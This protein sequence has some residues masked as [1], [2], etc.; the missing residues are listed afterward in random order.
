LKRIRAVYLDHL[1]T[2][3]E[4]YEQ[5]SR[6]LL[7]REVKQ[8]FLIHANEINADSIDEMVQRLKGRGYSF[9]TLER[10]LQDDAY[11][12]EDEYVGDTGISWLHRW[13]LTLGKKLDY[14]DDPDPPNF[15]LEL[16]RA[17]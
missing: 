10:A 14:R 12:L 3:F 5:R 7:G 6:M 4:Y 16:W 9:I 13:M 2:K 1:D 8:I 15:I 11:R 17:K